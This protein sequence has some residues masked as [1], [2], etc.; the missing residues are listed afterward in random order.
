[1]S[2]N[3]VEII[4]AGDVYNERFCYIKDYA[5]LTYINSFESRLNHSFL[6]TGL[7]TVHRCVVSVK[8]LSTID[9]DQ[10][11]TLTYRNRFRWK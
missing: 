4:S 8:L 6:T 11:K 3:N 2:Y 5:I 7:R 9:K 1:M 10:R